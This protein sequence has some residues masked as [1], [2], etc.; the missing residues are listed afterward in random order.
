V[1]PRPKRDKSRAG[2]S[3]EDIL[4]QHDA[5][6][7]AEMQELID[8]V[9]LEPEEEPAGEAKPPAAE[10]PPVP[11]PSP[12]PRRRGRTIQRRLDR[13]EKADLHAIE[14]TETV[15]MLRR[16]RPRRRGDCEGGQRPCAWVSCKWH[17][18]LDVNPSTGSIKV[19]FPHLEVWELPETCALDIAGR[20]GETLE[21]V[22]EFMNITR[23]RTRQ[24]EEK[25]LAQIAGDTK[26]AD[27]HTPEDR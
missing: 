24:I 16:L 12:H 21:E 22:G 9:E 15:T 4:A 3:V 11:E 8:E 2:S 14:R 18:Y 17:L 26:L 25:A 5:A 1:N 7:W 10:P 6:W 19:N 13:T 20:G 27:Y 23:E